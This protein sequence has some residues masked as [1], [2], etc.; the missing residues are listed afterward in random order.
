MFRFGR[1]GN[2]KHQDIC[3]AHFE[4]PRLFRTKE[5]EF[6]LLPG[7]EGARILHSLPKG[8]WLFKIPLEFDHR[9]RT[10]LARLLEKVILGEHRQRVK[11][12]PQLVYLEVSQDG[13][14]LKLGA[15]SERQ[16][17]FL[18]ED[19]NFDA[20]VSCDAIFLYRGKASLHMPDGSVYTAL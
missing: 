13:P 15:R 17:A 18:Y 14:W 4:S 16:E 20:W 19:P 6:V 5:E 8:E 11:V 9:L 2:Y 7:C 12:N 1:F 3:I 10:W